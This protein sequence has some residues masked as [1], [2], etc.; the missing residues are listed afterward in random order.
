MAKQNVTGQRFGRLTA[1]C[2]VD[3]SR[4]TTWTFACDCGTTK[5]APLYPVQ[6]GRIKSCG[7]LRD[8]VRS[9]RSRTH[10]HSIGATRTPELRSYR[11]MKER[12]LNKNHDVFSYYGGRG[13]TVCE[14]W[15]NSFQAFLDDMGPR[16][17]GMS[18]DRIDADGNYEP[19]NC[20]WA[21]PAEQSNN[22]RNN[23]VVT[24]GG[25]RMTLKQ[26]A[27]ECGVGY[28]ALHARVRQRGQS[29]DD[30]VAA[31]TRAM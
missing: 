28:K 12:C 26:Y 15:Q 1:I 19:R 20:R 30:A 31:L 23:V 11:K 8:E 14:R 17:P 29:L 10:G 21:T 2:R 5:S 18:L 13:I 4:R 24:V 25:L 27:L 6:N 16:P 9:A 7:C 3:G 22:R